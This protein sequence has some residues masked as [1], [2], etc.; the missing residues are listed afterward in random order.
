[1]AQQYSD[2]LVAQS[3]CDMHQLFSRVYLH[4]AALDHHCVE[5]DKTRGGCG[6][7][8]VSS[9]NEAQIG[10]TIDTVI[11]QLGPIVGLRLVL[12]SRARIGLGACPLPARI[13]VYKL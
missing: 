4:L 12:A 11:S 3:S 2:W 8:G 13:P 1:M 10:V 5:V 7:V 6:A 9:A